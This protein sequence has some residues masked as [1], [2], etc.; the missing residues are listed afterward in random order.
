MIRRISRAAVLGSGIMGSRI[1]C[2][3]ANTGIEVLLLDIVPNELTEAEKK[4]GLTADSKDFRNRIVNSSLVNAI[5]S[6]PS[7]LYK[8][9]FA[10]R[11]STGNFS[12][13]MPR[14]KDADWII[15]AVVENLDIKKKVFDEVEK[16]RK[17]GTLITT[18]TSGIPIKD[19]A[20]GRS[21]DFRKH[22]CGTHFFN[23]P[24]YLRLL[25]IIPGAD[26]D[27]GVIDFFMHYGDLFL[28]KST[29]QC[30]D[31]PAFIANRIGI[32]GI[33]SLFHLAEKMEMRVED[34]DNLTG[35][36]IGRPKS[37]TFRT[38]DVV[39]L[40]TLVHVAN[41]L[42]KRC[43]TDESKEKFRLPGFIS[44]MIENKWL[45]DKTKQGFYKKSLTPN[46]SPK[47]EGKKEILSLDLK[48]LEYKPQ[49]K[50]RF[51]SLD[52]LKNIDDL[53]ARLK[54][55]FSS[56]D[57]AGEFFRATVCDT[58]RYITHRIP[59][60]SS[61]IYKVDDALK[62]GFGWETGPFEL[63]D[64]IGL[65]E[66]ISACDKLNFK[67]APWVYEMKNAGAVSF[68]KYENGKKKYYDQQSKSYKEIPGAG[69]FIFIENLKA[70][71]NVIWKNAGADLMDTGDGILLLEWHTKMNT[72]G[73]EVLEAI[74]KS[75]D[76][77]EKD[78]RGLVIGNEGQN[79]SAGANLA[80][81]YMYAIE[82][83]YDEIDLAVRMF[84]NTTMRIKY[85]SVP[86]VVAPHG[87]TLGGGCEISMH[88]SKVQAYAET[89]IGLVEFGV[90]LIPAGGGTKEFAIRISDSIR[91]GDIELNILKENF[92]N[93][94]MA[95][96]ATS[97]HEAFDLNIFRKGKDAITLNK[98]RLISDAK[99]SCLEMADAGYSK[100]S[101]R[102]DIKVLGR[103]G[104]GM[105]YAGANVMYAGKFISEYDMFISKKLGYVLCGGELSSPSLV[106]EQYLLDLE[107]E[108]FVSLCGEK[109]TLERINS[110]LTTGKPLRN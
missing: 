66:F 93:I 51:A 31:T 98:K 69:N 10:S 14:L 28:G 25:E 22:F 68:Y 39:G 89:Y 37:A 73:G 55:F 81:V 32:Y 42:Y 85:A 24:R 36:L 90:G 95:K 18:N 45:G 38:C 87:L 33:M 71:K 106:S 29:V 100:P 49:K 6:N 20:E 91:E 57:K 23:P 92:L 110:I 79:F 59:E 54:N 97:A 46:S 58:F 40:D 83:E 4:R 67:L 61:E 52:T 30:K 16:H 72:I 15:E 41:D 2:H 50:T 74:S 35:T 17:P 88:A 80:L 105:V 47:G 107:R 75:I 34:I 64:I 11:I 78:F 96:V 26:T 70:E 104:L 108:A 62:A 109:K 13:D 12:E 101:L 82:Q 53:K 99:R 48:T 60:I 7:P 1:A 94:G 86:V 27:P 103:Q 76:I 84:Q 44:K 102:K 21:E 8:K 56:P 63:A 5:K 9:T 3:L 43:T 19:I 65:E 77:A